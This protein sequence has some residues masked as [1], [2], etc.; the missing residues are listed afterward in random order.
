[1]AT[2]E[3]YGSKTAFEV[4]GLGSRLRKARDGWCPVLGPVPSAS[5]ELPYG[6]KKETTAGVRLDGRW[7]GALRG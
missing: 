5:T 3:V 2:L 7:P 4:D 6:T 1:M